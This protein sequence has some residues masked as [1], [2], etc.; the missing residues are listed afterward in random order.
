MTSSLSAKTLLV[1]QM[2]FLSRFGGATLICDGADGA[3]VAHSQGAAFREVSIGRDPSPLADVRSVGELIRVLRELRPQVSILGTPKMSLLGGLAAWLVRVPVRIYVMHG[4]RLE[5]ATGL[6]RWLLRIAEW[7]TC[8]LATKVVVVGH[9]LADAA[10]SNR[11]LPR[12]KITILGA[13]TA[14][15]VDLDYFRV[16]T[17]AERA[18]ARSH[19]NY[20]DEERVALFVGR[21]TRDKGIRELAL[22]WPSI[23]SGCPHAR[24]VLA[25]ELELSSDIVESYRELSART[26]VKVLGHRDPRELYWAADVLLLPTYRE[27]FPTVVLEAAACGTPVITTRVTGSR[28]SVIE[29]VTGYLVEPRDAVALAEAVRSLIESGKAPAIGAAGRAHVASQFDRKVVWE[30]WRKLLLECGVT[31]TG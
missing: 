27:G 1:G 7:S 24:L 25:G 4:L 6:G 20:R 3:A 26:D 12:K 18:K 5:G 31:E 30:H 17:E 11:V 29:G 10:V 2:E 22:A 21:I 13:G 23:H 8:R 16:P 15:G 14:N 9:S 19:L 28:E